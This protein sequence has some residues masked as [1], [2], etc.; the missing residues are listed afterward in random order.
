VAEPARSRLDAAIASVRVPQTS[1][2]P[3]VV[4]PFEFEEWAR[5]GAVA[6]IRS[7]LVF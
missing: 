1:P 3:L 7:V 6:G 5:A 4:V 2:T